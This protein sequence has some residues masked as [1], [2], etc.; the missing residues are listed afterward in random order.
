VGDREREEPS[1]PIREASAVADQRKSEE[2]A[3][4]GEEFKGDTESDIGAD[5]RYDGRAGQGGKPESEGAT[6]IKDE[7]TDA[8]FGSTTD[9]RDGRHTTRPVEGQRASMHVEGPQQRTGG[10]GRMRPMGGEYED[11]DD[12]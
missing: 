6:A 8:E 2:T 3:G 9:G 7:E 10:D 11:D 1:T 5:I 12:D 4:G